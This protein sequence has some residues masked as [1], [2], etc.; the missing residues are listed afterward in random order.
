M[1]LKLPAQFEN[2]GHKIRCRTLFFKN[3]GGLPQGHFILLSELFAGHFGYAAVYLFGMG[4][5]L[6]G[7]LSRPA[8]VN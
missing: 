2:L 4:C 1:T 6:A 3:K 5:A 8:A 7:M